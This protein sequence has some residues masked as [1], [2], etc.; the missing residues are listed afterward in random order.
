MRTLF[1][2]LAHH[3]GA[4][5]VVDDDRT[6][7]LRAADH[8]LRDD[9]LVP[10]LEAV[11]AEAGLSFE[12]LT[13][14]ACVTGPGGF[15]SLRVAVAACNALAWER[16]IPILPIHGSDVM[17]ARVEGA[18]LLWLHSTRNDQ[19]FARGFGALATHFS[20]PTLSRADALLSLPLQGTPWA[21]ELIPAQREFL[22]PLG[23][24]EAPLRPIAAVLPALLANAKPAKAPIDPWY[25]RGW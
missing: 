5:A 18:D 7:A 20:E 3:D 19:L 25:G 14:I 2:D 9:G 10:L 22:A 23:L 24:I 17:R 8:R 12:T 16:T 11:L 15:T 21:G 4:V 13:H 1:L 6:L